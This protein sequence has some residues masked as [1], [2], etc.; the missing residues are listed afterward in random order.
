[1]AHEKSIYTKI[2]YKAIKEKLQTGKTSKIEKA[3]V[4]EELQIKKA[5]F[6]TLKKSNNELRGCIGTLIPSYKNLMLEII[7]NAVSSALN[8]NRFFSLKESELENI[9][10]SVEVLENP[11]NIESIDELDPKKYGIIVTGN[12]FRRAVLL[13]DIEGVDTVEQQI[14]ICKRKGGIIDD[15]IKIQ[16]FTTQKY[17]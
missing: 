17:Y 5:C 6:V 7:H 10:I 4:P 2:A 9:I 11:E 14:S 13:P 8:D 3:D 1:M 16:K 12:N 15:N